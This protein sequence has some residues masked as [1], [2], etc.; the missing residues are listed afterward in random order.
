MDT[1]KK[2]LLTI[3]FLFIGNSFFTYS[4]AP[5]T[6]WSR[7]YGSEYSDIAVKL[8]KTTD[9]DFLLL[10][11]AIV[12]RDSDYALIIKTDS[13][14][15]I[16]WSKNY[17]T[18]TDKVLYLFDGLILED[19]SLMFCGK[20]SYTVYL[21]RTDSL[22]NVLWDSSYDSTGSLAFAI[23][24]T[25]MNGFITT[26]R[27]YYGSS[28]SLF[29][30]TGNKIGMKIFNTTDYYQLI[31]IERADADNYLLTGAASS[32]PSFST[33][34]LVKIDESGDTLWSKNLTSYLDYSSG[35]SIKRTIDNNYIIAGSIT[36]NG[37]SYTNIYL[38][39]VDKDGDIIWEKNL[40]RGKNDYAKIAK[41][42]EDGGFIIIGNSL[43]Q[44]SYDTKIL[45]VKTDSLGNL[46]WSKEIGIGS[47]EG[48]DVEQTA[49][50]GY[51]VLAWSAFSATTGIDYWLIKLEPDPPQSAENQNDLRYNFALG[52]NYPNP[53][54]PTTTID[55]QIPELS[56]VTLKI[57]DVLGNEVA[58]LENQ[59]KPAGNYEV[60]FGT[61]NLPSGIY[62]YR[63]QAG[64]FTETK[65]M[66]LI[67]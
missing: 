53:F 30:S 49:D 13:N 6:L 23:E 9:E 61:T 14:G 62:F 16:L 29:D 24:R 31:D 2:I 50:G 43:E 65:K 38:C 12:P 10:G 36:P 55:Y 48:V 20:K 67:K 41:P 19:N 59:E 66:V 46:I 17:R 40:D 54:N 64:S 44:S 4:Q 34:L 52:L 37:Q 15:N 8:I 18:N 22:G 33:T 7:L 5:D 39:K 25:T 42:T 60:K 63:I 47:E 45:V 26:N 57:Y 28:I 58:I 32:P 1:S 35:R 27:W 21:M 51:I 56:F 3:A 11:Y